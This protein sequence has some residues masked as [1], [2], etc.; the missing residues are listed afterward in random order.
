MAAFTQFNIIDNRIKIY[1][2]FMM[3]FKSIHEH[4]SRITYSLGEGVEGW[5]GGG[6][7]EVWRRSINDRW[8]P[9][10]NDQ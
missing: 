5:G 10:T 3:K 2:V 1:A 9:L 4:A 6:G 7:G 8:I